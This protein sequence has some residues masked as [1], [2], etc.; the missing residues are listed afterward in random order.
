MT[1]IDIRCT[2][3]VQLDFEESK[4]KSN[5]LCEEAYQT[6][7]LLKNLS[8]M[9]QVRRTLEHILEDMQEEKQILEQ[10]N[11]CLEESCRVY[12]SYENEIT[13]YAEE[14]HITSSNE[15]KIGEIVIPEN[16]FRILR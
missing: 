10:M 1:L 3:D 11:K 15:Q 2:A 9:Q 6:S 7:N 4:R 8:G 5:R 12:G 13:E 16:I 14:S